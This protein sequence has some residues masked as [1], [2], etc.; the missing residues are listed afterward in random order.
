MRSH[1]RDP[2]LAWLLPLAYAFHILEEWFGGFPEWIALVVGSPL[3]RASFIVISAIAM[4][5]MIVATRAATASERYAWAGVAV[6][7]ILL[8]NALTHAL[9]TVVTGTYSPGMTTALL[10]YVPLAGLVL[11]RAVSQAQRSVFR[12]GLVT[13]IGVH[14]LVFVVAY[15]SAL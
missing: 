6:A 2:R 14:A 12:T 9:G 7:T 4:A 13:G 8:V 10:L 1:Y 3:P 11:Q 15:V 5:A